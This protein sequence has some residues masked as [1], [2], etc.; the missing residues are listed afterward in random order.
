MSALTQCNYCTLQQMKR[1]AEQ[2]GV[3]VIIGHDVDW[4]TA[5]YS[6]REEPSAMFLQLTTHCVC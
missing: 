5:R 4:I 6:D 2:I 3:E 1:N